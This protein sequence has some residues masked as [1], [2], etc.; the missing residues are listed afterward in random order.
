MLQLN[1]LFWQNKPSGGYVIM[2]A[3]SARRQCNGRLL[4][5]LHKAVFPLARLPA[6]RVKS[7]RHAEPDLRSVRQVR[8]KDALTSFR[9]AAGGTV[10]A[11]AN[12]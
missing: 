6:R 5:M 8:C 1:Q 4:S 9:A 12:R 2:T 7:A 10:L 11:P 3:Q